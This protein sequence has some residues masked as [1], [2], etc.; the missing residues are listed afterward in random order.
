M[1]QVNKTV[2]HNRPLHKLLDNGQKFALI[3]IHG[4]ILKTACYEYQLN[5]AK[6]CNFGSKIVK[7]QDLLI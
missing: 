2:K 1:Y 5:V 4:K 7:T 6:K 3:D